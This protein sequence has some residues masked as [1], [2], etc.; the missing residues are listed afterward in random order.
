MVPLSTLGVMPCVA[1]SVATSVVLQDALDVEVGALAS[2]LCHA[3]PQAQALTKKIL[4]QVWDGKLE[5]KLEIAA[6]F[7][8]EAR[9]TDDCKEGVAAFI[10][11]RKPKWQSG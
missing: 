4:P 11:K 7:N 5:D 3:S 10:E 2:R 8:A 9:A 1:T 6:Q